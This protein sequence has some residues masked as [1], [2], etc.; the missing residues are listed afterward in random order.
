MEER[1]RLI[2]ERWKRDYD[3]KL[4]QEKGREKEKKGV[5]RKIN[6]IAINDGAKKG[7]KKK[8]SVEND[9]G[10][11]NVVNGDGGARS[12]KSGGLE[13]LS[14]SDL[15]DRLNKT[16]SE[17][18]ETLV[19]LLSMKGVKDNVEFCEIF[20][21]WMRGIFDKVIDTPWSVAN[22]S[23]KTSIGTLP[24]L[25]SSTSLSL[26]DSRRPPNDKVEATCGL[27][28]LKLSTKSS[29][30]KHLREVHDMV[31]FRK[32]ATLSPLPPTAALLPDDV[33]EGEKNDDES[34]EVFLREVTHDDCF[35]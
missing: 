10:E 2:I 24:S 23:S 22:T 32:A 15:I 12:K 14:E 26:K 18:L 21:R 6:D 29:L 30:T 35:C 4:E 9:G 7:K 19:T 25:S 33:A 8:S 31:K 28:H 27:C 13:K 5:K 20:E 1:A 16:K 34:Y 11:E 17:M 3:V